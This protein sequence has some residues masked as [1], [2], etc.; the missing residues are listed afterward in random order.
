MLTLCIRSTEHGIH[1]IIETGDCRMVYAVENV[2]VTIDRN[3]D[4]GMSEPRL[5]YDSRYAAFNASCCKCMSQCMLTIERN[6]CFFADPSVEA[7]HLCGL[8]YT[9][10]IEVVKQQTI[11]KAKS[12]ETGRPSS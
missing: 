10:F 3:M 1:I 12:R 7:V 2:A 5:K 11:R 4:I 6:P 9:I 8:Y